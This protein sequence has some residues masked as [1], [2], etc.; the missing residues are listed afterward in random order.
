MS[1]NEL[2]TASEIANTLKPTIGEV[3][4][5]LKAENL[6]RMTIMNEQGIEMARLRHQIEQQRKQITKLEDALE[7]LSE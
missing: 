7:V 3:M 6:T 2:K 4:E 5:K 1:M